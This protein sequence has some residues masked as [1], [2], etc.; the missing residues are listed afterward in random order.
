MPTSYMKLPYEDRVLRPEALRSYDLETGPVGYSLDIGLNYYRGLPLS[1][2]ESLELTVDAEPVPEHL[3][4]VELNGKLFPTSQLSAAFT[5]FWPIKKDLRIYVFNG[6]IEDG[7]HQVDLRLILR[8]VYMQF[9]PGVW[10]MID[11][12]A[13]RTLTLQGER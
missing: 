5:E 8:C 3:I 4:L 10:G 7:P 6:G 13:S 9:A 1:A 2:V 12:S 11:N